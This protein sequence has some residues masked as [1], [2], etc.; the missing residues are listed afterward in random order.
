MSY[1]EE[2]DPPRGPPVD[3]NTCVPALLPT[4]VHMASR[5]IPN[6]HEMQSKPTTPVRCYLTPVKVVTVRR[7]REKAPPVHCV[8]E[9][10]CCNHYGKYRCAP[11]KLKQELPQD[12]ARP[13]PAYLREMKSVSLRGIYMAMST[14]PLF[15]VATT[16]KPPTCP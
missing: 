12:P 9:S 3:T 15:T 2:S 11:Q 1:Q 5:R 14:A 10:A 8:W 4:R 6:H 13:F 7:T 16:R